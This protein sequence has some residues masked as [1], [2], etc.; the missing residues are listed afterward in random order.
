M[1]LKK[2]E[3]PD[4][5]K[6]R[7]LFACSL[8]TS[9]A[10]AI[11][12]PTVSCFDKL[13]KDDI[14]EK[15][16]GVEIGIIIVLLIGGYYI[17][18]ALKA[19]PRCKR[20]RFI[21][22]TIALLLLLSVVV[23]V[24]VTIY[25][26]YKNENL[27]ND[28]TDRFR[29]VVKKE[30]GFY[31]NRNEDYGSMMSFSSGDGSVWKLFDKPHSDIDYD[32]SKYARGVVGGSTAYDVA[33]E[34]LKNVKDHNETLTEKSFKIY[35]APAK[36][37]WLSNKDVEGN[38]GSSSEPFMY[39]YLLEPYAINFY[40]PRA[41]YDKKITRNRFGFPM[42]LEPILS[43]SEIASIY[44]VCNLIVDNYVE[45][46][47]LKSYEKSGQGYCCGHSGV[48]DGIQNEYYYISDKYEGGDVWD[49]LDVINDNPTDFFRVRKF[50]LVE[51]SE[52][53][54]IFGI[55]RMQKWGVKERIAR[56]HFLWY[57]SDI[58]DI[59]VAL[60]T[61]FLY[62]FFMYD[63]IIFIMLLLISWLSTK[64]DVMYYLRINLI[65]VKEFSSKLL[66]SAVPRMP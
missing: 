8:V 44:G 4:W 27:K 34:A 53:E 57:S 56:I 6:W 25:L 30:K 23:S 64:D 49:N 21:K 29:D 1:R 66:R 39:Y 5:C 16:I 2:D 13:P 12:R 17:I 58:Q 36:E 31:N 42:Y 37:I 19:F 3:Y 35:Y 20:N 26:D 47:Q 14:L 48:I 28:I 24:A 11:G 32:D 38:N 54:I 40:E 65:K 33:F 43:P 52:F 51:T 59:H 10:F 9:E 15:I 41:V 45:D 50:K 46:M 63:I 7:V 60:R 61:L 62:K 18:K 55:T 22:R